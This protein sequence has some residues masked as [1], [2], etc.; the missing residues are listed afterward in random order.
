MLSKEINLKVYVDF[1]GNG[2]NFVRELSEW[3]TIH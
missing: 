3:L 2:Y 1:Q